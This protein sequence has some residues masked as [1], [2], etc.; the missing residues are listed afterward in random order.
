MNCWSWSWED[1]TIALV[2]ALKHLQNA[3]AGPVADHGQSACWIAD[4]AGEKFAGDGHIHLRKDV[5]VG[6][7]LVGDALE[8]G[9]GVGVTTQPAVHFGKAEGDKDELFLLV[10]RLEDGRTSVSATHTPIPA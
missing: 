5:V 6:C 10:P 8:H 7:R 2:R 4:R 3:F 9:S 1:R